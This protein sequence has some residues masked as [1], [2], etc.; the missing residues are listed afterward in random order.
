MRAGRRTH[1]FPFWVVPADLQLSRSL[2]QFSLWQQHIVPTPKAN[3]LSIQVAS[4]QPNTDPP[5]TNWTHRLPFSRRTSICAKLS[6][7]KYWISSLLRTTKSEINFR[8]TYPFRL[9]SHISGFWNLEIWR[10]AKINTHENFLFSRRASAR[11]FL[12]IRIW[13]HSLAISD[14]MGS[15]GIFHD[16]YFHLGV[17]KKTTQN[18][19]N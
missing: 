9:Y 5:I 7:N 1:I 10:C 2:L 17:S 11:K 13:T 6:E 14:L 3:V 8:K 16:F 4:L 19:R 15:V 18:T 12:R